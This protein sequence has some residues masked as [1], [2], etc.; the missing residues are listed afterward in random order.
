MGG[1]STRASDALHAMAKAR[2]FTHARALLLRRAPNRRG[3]Y[4]QVLGH[5]LPSRAR[6]KVSCVIDIAAD[7]LNGN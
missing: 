5:G 4:V 2:I 1:L 7:T 6:P 3:E